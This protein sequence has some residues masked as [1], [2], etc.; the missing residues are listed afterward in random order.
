MNMEPEISKVLRQP[1]WFLSLGCDGLLDQIE[2]DL[3]ENAR[4]DTSILFT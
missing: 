1:Q 2:I 4:P 3:T